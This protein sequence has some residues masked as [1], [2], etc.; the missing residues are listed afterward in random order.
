MLPLLLEVDSEFVELGRKVPSQRKEVVLIR[1]MF[2]HSHERSSEA[3][4]PRYDVHARKVVDF[5]VGMH[6]KQLLWEEG[7]IHPANVP[8]LISL[9]LF[10]LPPEH[11]GHLLHDRIVAA[12]L[13]KA[14]RTRGVN[15]DAIHVQPI[16]TVLIKF[17][18]GSPLLLFLAFA[19]LVRVLRAGLG[20]SVRLLP[21]H[22]CY[23]IPS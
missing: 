12:C 9:R 11:T 5:L 10:Y 1:S 20:S 18:C 4:L 15:D 7:S 13:R 16:K 19:L 23:I 6:T 17:L 3:V 14:S 8:I 21:P 2:F 22:R